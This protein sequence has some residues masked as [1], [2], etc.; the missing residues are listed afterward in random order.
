M[1]VS[2]CKQIIDGCEYG[3]VQASFNEDQWKEFMQ[4]G[5][6][7]A[8]GHSD[9]LLEFLGAIND[10]VGAWNGVTVYLDAEGLIKNKCDDEDCPYFKQT[11]KMGNPLKA[12][13]NN[14]L[15]AWKIETHL[16]GWS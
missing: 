6:V 12:V 16:R 15:P 10:E 4:S 2:E 8:Y 7:I 1:N 5:L 3:K 13:W 14:T 11:K 9:D